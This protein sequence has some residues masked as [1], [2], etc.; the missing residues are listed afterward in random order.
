M[1]SFFHRYF[2]SSAEHKNQLYSPR[3]KFISLKK[4]CFVK[5]VVLYKWKYTGFR[6]KSHVLSWDQWIKT[7]LWSEQG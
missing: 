4:L 3:H 1:L 6:E 7:V 5:H 2:L